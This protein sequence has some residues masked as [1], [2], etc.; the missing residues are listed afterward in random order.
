MHYTLLNKIY[1]LSWFCTDISN[2]FM[3]V[4]ESQWLGD[5]D[6]VNKTL[7]LWTELGSKCVDEILNKWLKLIM[8][9]TDKNLFSGCMHMDHACRYE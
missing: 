1:G 4:H 5:A 6:I 9:I 2:E 3:N 7:R 8:G